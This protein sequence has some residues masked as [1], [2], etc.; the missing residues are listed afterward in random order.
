MIVGLS[1]ADAAGCPRRDA[2]HLEDACV[3]GQHTLATSSTQ[4]VV[5]LTSA[6]SEY[7]SMER[8]A[9]EATALANTTRELG[10][11]AQKRI[12]TDAAAAR[13]LALRSGSGTIKHM[14]TKYCWLQQKEK[15]QKL[16]IEK[17]RGAV[18]PAD[19]MRKHLDGKRFGKVM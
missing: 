12:W 14:E 6:E 15:N 8:C 7:Y 4:K 19:L 11:E 1:D 18:N 9:S 2:R 16:R 13:G 3:M 5:S 10:H 17:I